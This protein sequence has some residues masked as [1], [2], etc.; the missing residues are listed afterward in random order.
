[1]LTELLVPT[2]MKLSIELCETTVRVT[3]SL[4]GQRFDNRFGA[5]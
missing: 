2:K 4:F 1:M 3:D 5:K